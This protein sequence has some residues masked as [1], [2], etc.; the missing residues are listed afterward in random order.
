[1]RIGIKP[2]QW[3]WTFA[4]LERAW[5]EAEAAGFAIISSFD[6]VT[7]APAGAAAW[8]A[9]SLLCAMAGKTERAV[10]AVDVINSSLRNP[11]FLAGQLAV[12]QAASG[13]RLEVGLGAG[14]YHLARFDHGALGIEF[15]KHERRLRRLE[16][17]CRILP[18]LWRGE[19]VSDDELGLYDA[20]LGPLGIQQPPIFVG[21][22]SEGI[23]AIAARHGEGW[24]AVEHDPEAYAALA[25]RADELAE[26]PLRKTVQIFL[27]DVDIGTL[28]DRLVEFERVGA[29]SATIVLTEE[30]PEGVTRV[31]GAV[32]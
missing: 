20:A 17:C 23:L 8:D 26:K 9:P 1:V 10:I 29:E 18:A 24:N 16:A 4:D 25:R 14:S 15:P 13:G 3:G 21:G 19:R 30:G 27:R 32:L 11:F 7:A 6:H 5:R 28:R 12:A 22:K 31:A 2:G